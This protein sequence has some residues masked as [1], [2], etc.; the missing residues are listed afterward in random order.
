MADTPESEI[1]TRFSRIVAADGYD[2]G[3]QPVQWQALLYLRSANRF[4]RTPK[5]LTAWLGQTKGSVSQ[6]LATLEKKQLVTR[7]ADPADQ[8]VVRLELTAAAIDLVAGPPPGLAAQ[9]LDHL[10]AAER[11]QFTALVEQMLRTQLKRSGGR[12]FGRCRDCRHFDPGLPGT[13]QHRCRLLDVP[14]SAIDSGQICVEQ[15]AA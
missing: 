3:L 8:R 6:T 5:A 14:L 2:R 7:E 9:M 4:S 1:L 11:R 12:P 13:G 10:N 15:E